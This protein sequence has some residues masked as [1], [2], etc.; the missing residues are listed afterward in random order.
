V[1]VRLAAE[2]IRA[3]ASVSHPCLTRRLC[4][5]AP[6]LGGHAARARAGRPAFATVRRNGLSQIARELG[7]GAEIR[8]LDARSQSER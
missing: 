1:N 7:L 3:A 6:S 4:H 8:D 2:C 5:Q